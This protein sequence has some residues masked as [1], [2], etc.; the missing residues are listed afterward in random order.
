MALT[1]TTTRLA[2]EAA[3]ALA[4]RNGTRVLSIEVVTPDGRTWAIDP[5]VSGCFRLFEIDHD[6]ERG[7]DEH[8]AVDGEEWHL[9]DLLDYLDAVGQRKTK[10]AT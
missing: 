2:I 4:R 10:P 9:S 1:P 8:H 3:S 6:R 5:K 7:P